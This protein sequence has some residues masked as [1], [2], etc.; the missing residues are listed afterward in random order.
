MTIVDAF[1]REHVQIS[2]AIT[3]LRDMVAGDPPDD[4]GP[5]SAARWRL[6]FLVAKHVSVED[7]HIFPIIAADIRSEVQDVIARFNG[8]INVIKNDFRAYQS[9]WPP[10]RIMAEWPGFCAATQACLNE[11]EKRIEVEERE[12]FPLV[13]EAEIR[14]RQATGGA[15]IA[16]EHE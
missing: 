13:R 1:A 8:R 12:L 15:W 5:I 11:L 7:T 14:L 9:D 4:L 3:H 2:T 6:G 10:D 16:P